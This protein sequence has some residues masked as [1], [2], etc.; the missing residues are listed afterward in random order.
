MPK[1]SAKYTLIIVPHLISGRYRISQFVFNSHIRLSGHAIAGNGSKLP[2]TQTGHA[3]RPNTKFYLSNTL[4]APSIVKN[5]I[6]VR[7]F[8]GDNSR[9]V[10]FDSFGFF[11][12]N[13]PSKHV[14]LKGSSS[15]LYPSMAPGA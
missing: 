15:D 13:L 7:K 2:I 11:V 4:I 10:G 12:K 3:S 8:T 9:S 5:L 1:L 6:Y 14:T